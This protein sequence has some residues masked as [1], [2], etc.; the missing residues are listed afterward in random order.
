MSLSFASARTRVQSDERQCDQA[1]RL[2]NSPLWINMPM[3]LNFRSLLV[4]SIVVPCTKDTFQC[5]HACHKEG[6]SNCSST[7]LPS[8]LLCDMQDNC[9]E[10]ETECENEYEKV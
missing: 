10:D 1:Y 8:T 5:S 7:C 2:L 9:M 6:E 4:I 3:N